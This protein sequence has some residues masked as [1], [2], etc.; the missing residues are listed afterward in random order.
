MATISEIDPG[1]AGLAQIW[2]VERW[3]PLG[4]QPGATRCRCPRGGVR[5][6]HCVESIRRILWHRFVHQWR[7]ISLE[8][9]PL[10]RNRRGWNE[11]GRVLRI[12]HDQ[13]VE[14]AALEAT[15]R[16]IRPCLAP[17]I[18]N[19][20]WTGGNPSLQNGQVTIDAVSE[21]SDYRQFEVLQCTAP[22]SAQQFTIPAW[23]LSVLAPSGGS[24]SRN[25]HRH[26][27]LPGGGR[28]SV[29]RVGQALG[30]DSVGI[31]RREVVNE[32]VVQEKE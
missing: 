1:T 2:R 15:F 10:C 18:F 16:P 23:A 7:K 5:I 22:L 20:K 6:F 24:G 12:R 17:A 4:F 30:L 8:R 25:H 19:S 31:N 27:L 9:P 13:R 29:N 21:S 3:K 14:I 26:F 11:C 32:R 28:F